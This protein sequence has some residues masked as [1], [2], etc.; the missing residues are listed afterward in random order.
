[1]QTGSLGDIIFEV[2]TAKILTPNGVSF[3]REAS[4]EDHEVQGDYPR[5]EFLH[6]GLASV[7][8]A[9]TLR[10]DLG[11]DP[12]SEAEAL[13]FKMIDGEVLRLVIA[14]QNLGKYTIRKIDQSWRHCLK[15][16]TGPLILDLSLELKE[17]W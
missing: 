15:G 6:P 5:P 13:E 8:L 11:C 1:M 9:I 14:G 3:S 17:Y 10:A 16:R 12:W 7:S 2:S 4:F